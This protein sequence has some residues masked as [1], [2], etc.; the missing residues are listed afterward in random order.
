MHFSDELVDMFGEWE[1]DSDAESEELVWREDEDEDDLECTENHPLYCITP[2]CRRNR[3]FIRGECPPNWVS[4]GENGYACLQ[5]TLAPLS[6][7]PSPPPVRSSPSPP[8]ILTQ[9]RSTTPPTPESPEE[10]TVVRPRPV[11]LQVARRSGG[12]PGQGT[13]NPATPIPIAELN[14]N[15]NDYVRWVV[16]SGE[17]ED[18]ARLCAEYYGRVDRLVGGQNGLLGLFRRA[19]EGLLRSVG[20]E[21]GFYERLVSAL[22]QSVGE[23]LD[24]V[25]GLS[26]YGSREGELPLSYY[27]DD[28]EEKEGTLLTVPERLLT[29]SLSTRRTIL[30]DIVLSGNNPTRF[31]YADRYASRTWSYLD[32]LYA[33][34]TGIDLNEEQAMLME[35]TLRRGCELLGRMRVEVTSTVK[36]VFGVN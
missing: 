19:Q 2:R 6:S 18:K 17:V 22:V 10:M 21:I 5:R 13:D 25:F 27:G 8:P 30:R 12:P 29:S 26:R 15:Y 23:M 16:E 36:Q 20:F 3:S 11:R 28:E 31:W 24:D 1:E 4:L 7:T 33:L 34:I 32:V 9:S 35:A 14:A